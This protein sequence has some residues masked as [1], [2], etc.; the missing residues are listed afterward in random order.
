MSLMEPLGLTP[1]THNHKLCLGLNYPSMK[2]KNLFHTSTNQ[3]EFQ[4]IE[5]GELIVSNKLPAILM[6]FLKNIQF[7]FRL[8]LVF[9]SYK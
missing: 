8:S 5:V 4:D 7:C 6:W 2:T 9:D 1:G 3:R